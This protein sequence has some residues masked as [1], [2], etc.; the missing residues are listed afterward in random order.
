MERHIRFWFMVPPHSQF[1]S[2]I[3]AK[4]KSVVFG[5]KSS[6]KSVPLQDGGAGARGGAGGTGGGRKG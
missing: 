3:V 4:Q 2:F 5:K 6:P 1:T